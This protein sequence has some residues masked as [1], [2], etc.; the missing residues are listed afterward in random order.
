LNPNSND[1]IEVTP[2][3]GDEDSIFGV[4]TSN[5]VILHGLLKNEL[6]LFCHLHVKPEDSMLPFSWWKIHETQIS[7]VSFMAQQILEIHGSQIEAKRIFS[8]VWVLT[9]F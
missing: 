2:V 5:E 4:M 7:N 1:L 8:I 3:D 6:N 9:S